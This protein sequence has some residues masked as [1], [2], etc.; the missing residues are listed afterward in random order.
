MPGQ[1]VAQ[2]AAAIRH[3]KGLGCHDPVLVFYHPIASYNPYQSLLYGQ[4]WE[5]GAAA[6]PLHDLDELPDIAALTRTGAHVVLHLHWTN[7]VLEGAA[8]DEAARERMLAFL[9]QLD[10]FRSAGGHLVWTIHNV[11][12]HD[13]ERPGLE[14][15][16]Q[17]AIVDRC[18]LVH[19]LSAN[20]SEVVA[21]WFSVPAT[22]TLHVPHPSYGGAYVDTISRT[23]ARYE[24]GIAPD[25]TVYALLG[26]IKPYK[27]ADRLLDAF[28]VLCERDP[29]RRRLIVAGLPD[30]TGAVEPFLER[31]ELHP[32]VK[33]FARRILPEEMPVFLRAADIV[34]LPYLRVLNSGVLM[35]ALTFGLPVV[36]PAVG[37]LAETLTPAVGRTF[38]ADEDDGLL[39]A[40]ISADELRTEAARSAALALALQRDPRILSAAFASSLTARV[41]GTDD[42]RGSLAAT[43]GEGARPRTSRPRKPTGTA[44]RA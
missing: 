17:Q 41:R 27:G 35:L 21:E 22:K 2:G 43:S 26:A 16:L 11:L 7:K 29:A 14:A 39:E 44:T 24:L 3:L 6:I 8:T 23:E 38:P 25:E 42:G 1:L 37:G 9:G 18:D 28:D 13:C 40:L 30:R 4:M 31:C 15:E 12:P 10:A 34:V 36:A 5:H 32:F 20:T 33:L 19:V